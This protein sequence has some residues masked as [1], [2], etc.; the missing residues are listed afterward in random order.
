MEYNKIRLS[1]KCKPCIDFIDKLL[2]KDISK[3]I[4]ADAALKH[5]WFQIYKI[6]KS[7]Y[8]SS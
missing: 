3:R 1:K 4:M 8:W 2:E 7:A 6:N 5:K